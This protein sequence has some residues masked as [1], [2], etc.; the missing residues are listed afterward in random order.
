MRLVM[1]FMVGLKALFTCV[2]RDSL[3]DRLSKSASLALLISASIDACVLLY[4]VSKL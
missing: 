2:T 1:V 4:M 3:S